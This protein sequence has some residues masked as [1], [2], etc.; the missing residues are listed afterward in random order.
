MLTLVIDGGVPNVGADGGAAATMDLV[1]GLK[2]IGHEVYFYPDGHTGDAASRDLRRLGDIPVPGTPFGGPAG[3][4]P[5]VAANR[6]RLDF[7]IAARPGPASRH[8]PLLAE[9]TRAIRIYFGHDIHYRRMAAGVASGAP[10][11]PLQLRGMELVERRLWREFD[12][13][14]YPSREE[15]REVE[16]REPTAVAVEM[17]IFALDVPEGGDPGPDRTRRDAL[18]VGGAFHDPNRDGVAWF[19]ANILPHVRAAL[20]DFTL[21][22]AGNW[23]EAMREPIRRDGVVFLGR[24]EAGDLASEIRRAR[25]SVAPLRFGGGVKH[26]VVAAMANGLPVV[27]TPA[28]LE[29]LHADEGKGELALCAN[30]AATF[31]TSVLKLANDGALWSRLSAAG[32]DFCRS[33]YSLA[34]YDAALRR[35]LGAAKKARRLSWRPD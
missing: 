8:L 12:L 1:R 27:S 9:L 29:G 22:V 15:R 33:R 14:V 24:V 21:R 31:A 10:Y 2:R 23:P 4:A 26:K 6:E 32:R 5:W 34:A 11:A 7:V 20:P 19:A 18:F 13:V 25:M 17:P 16:A 35:V 28:G 3:L 30:D